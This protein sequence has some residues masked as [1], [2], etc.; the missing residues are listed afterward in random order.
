MIFEKDYYLNSVVSNYK[1]YRAK[2]FNDLALDLFKELQLNYDSKIFDFGAATGGLISSFKKIGIKNVVGTDISYWAI[3]YGRTFYGLDKNELQLYNRQ[4]LEDQFDVIFLL[5]VLEHID[6]EELNLILETIKCN[7]LVIR[8]PVAKNE[9]E[10]FVL[11]VSKNDKTHIQVHSKDWWLSL[12]N[13]YGY[14]VFNPIVTESIYDS[15]GVIAG[16]LIRN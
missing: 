11:D 2:K 10:D 3:K 5:D 7:K 6:I 8:M 14:Y 1:D 15:D 9:G 16:V 13:K 4:L 12:F